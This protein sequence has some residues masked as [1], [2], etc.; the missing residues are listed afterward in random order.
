MRISAV[1]RYPLAITRMAR[2]RRM[3]NWANSK[4]AVI[5]SHT[6]IAV[7]Y[8]GTKAATGLVRMIDSGPR[9]INPKTINNPSTTATA[10]RVCAGPG[11]KVERISCSSSE[12]MAA[13]FRMGATLRTSGPRCIWAWRTRPAGS[14]TCVSRAE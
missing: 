7:A 10:R 13:V 9:V 8:T 2:E 3:E 5:E 6:N 14:P 11:D 1:K 12:R 4:I